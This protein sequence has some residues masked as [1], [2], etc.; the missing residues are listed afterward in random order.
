LR[1]YVC[2]ICGYVYDE[3]LGDNKR[4]IAPGTKWEELPGDWNCP[5]CGAVKA[6]FLE[7]KMIERNSHQND[8]KKEDDTDTVNELS[9][10]EIIALLS[11]LSKGCAKQYRPEEAELFSQLADFYQTKSI[12]TGEGQLKDLNNLMDE[13]VTTR[14]SEAS[15]IASNVSDR[16]ALRAL[17]WGEK[18]TRILNSILSRYEKLQDT[19]LENTRIYVCDICGFIY[20]GDTLPDICPVCKVPNKKISEVKRR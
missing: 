4:E 11:N 19:L 5:L 3:A 6:D 18:V 7:E 14:Y 10:G 13:D 9:F 16:G 17:V 1:K 2:S 15:V 12:G 20:I 8:D